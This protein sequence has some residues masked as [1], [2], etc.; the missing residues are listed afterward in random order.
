MSTFIK[1]TIGLD[2]NGHGMSGKLVHIEY[3]RNEDGTVT[4]N[5]VSARNLSR[6]DRVP[7]I[8]ISA[9]AFSDRPRDP[10]DSVIEARWALSRCGWTLMAEDYEGQE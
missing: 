4:L 3:V 2:C 10:Y 7:S 8:T 6:I 5:S 9:E 1:N